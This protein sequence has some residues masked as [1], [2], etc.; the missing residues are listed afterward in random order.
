MR[1]WLKQHLWAYIGLMGLV[2]VVVLPTCVV[3]MGL[4]AHALLVGSG[5]AVMGG[6]GTFIWF[7]WPDIMRA[8]KTL[9]V[10]KDNAVLDPSEEA[11]VRVLVTHYHNTHATDVVEYLQVLPN[12]RCQDR[13][14]AEI[15]K[16]KL[17]DLLG[18]PD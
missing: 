12:D 3:A 4:T 17:G 15:A 8:H 5:A 2:P 6:T 1:E 13:F 18:D 11:I 16:L 14:L 10:N 7:V 9:V